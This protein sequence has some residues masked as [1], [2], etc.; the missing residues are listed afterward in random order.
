MSETTIAATTDMV[1]RLVG[2]DTVSANS[3]LD[4][5]RWVADYLAG[6]GIDA[7]LT[8]DEGRNKANLFATIGPAEAGGGVILSGHT[9]VVP[10]AGQPWDSDPFT[11][12]ERDGKLYGRGTSDMKSFIAIA[13]SL[14]PEFKSR[15]LR[16]PLHLAL[17]FD[18]EVGCFGVRRF[19]PAYDGIA[20]IDGGIQIGIHE[21]P[22]V[23]MSVGDSASARKHPAIN[24]GAD[25]VC[26]K[27]AALVRP[28]AIPGI[29]RMIFVT[30]FHVEC[31]L[32]RF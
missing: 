27:V 26:C 13:L 14:V 7:H 23:M 4:L 6:H 24:P 12:L 32:L 2:F 18:E 11:L 25:I 1:R 8:Y 19:S 30:G 21:L 22:D 10:V 16:R 28:L 17:S 3:N 5:I 29:H 15:K 20:N 31:G 9:D